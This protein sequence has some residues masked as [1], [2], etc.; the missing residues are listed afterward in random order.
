MDERH[1]LRFVVRGHRDRVHASPNLRQES[2]QLLFA[3]TSIL[4][5]TVPPQDITQA[6]LKE[7]SKLMREIYVDPMEEFNLSPFIIF[8]FI[9][10][11]MNNRIPVALNIKRLL[12][13]LFKNKFED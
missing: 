1:K 7:T 8:K 2:F 10:L 6:Y 5:F 3:I 13:Q 11:Y 4:R 12:P 9:K